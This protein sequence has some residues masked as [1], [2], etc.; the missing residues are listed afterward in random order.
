MSEEPKFV[1]SMYASAE[2][3]Y[4]A[5]SDYYQG[6]LSLLEDKVSDLEAKLA[7][8]DEF[9]RAVATEFYYHWHNSPGTNTQQGF[10][11]WWELNRV[12]FLP[13]PPTE[14]GK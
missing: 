8:R 14:D 12:R 4:K 3:L 9:A 10:Q 11:D 13:S 6:V 5:K 2:D 7:E 1:M